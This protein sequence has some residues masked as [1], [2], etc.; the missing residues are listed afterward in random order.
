MRLVG[1]I[2]SVKESRQVVVV[3]LAVVAAAVCSGASAAES[4]ANQGGASVNATIIGVGADPEGE[5]KLGD[6][7]RQVSEWL[8]VKDSGVQRLLIVSAVIVLVL[9]IVVSG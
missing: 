6:A 5:W 3:L 9:A 1:M 2:Q 4:G 7:L 8:G